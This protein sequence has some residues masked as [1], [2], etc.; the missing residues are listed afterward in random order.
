MIGSSENGPPRKSQMG[1]NARV[2]SMFDHPFGQLISWTQENSRS[3]ASDMNQD[4][5]K[6]WLSLAQTELG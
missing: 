5:Q 2:F 1:L 6:H 3:H 4:A